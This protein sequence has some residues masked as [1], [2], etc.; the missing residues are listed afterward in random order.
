MFVLTVIQFRNMFS[1][2]EDDLWLVQRIPINM[3]YIFPKEG[4][5]GMLSCELCAVLLWCCYHGNKRTGV[6]PN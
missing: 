4:L 3:I 1:L 6:L 5:K 2:S